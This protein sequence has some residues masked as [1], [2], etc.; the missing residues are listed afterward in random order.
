MNDREPASELPGWLERTRV[1]HQTRNR[2]RWLLYGGGGA[3]IAVVALVG[4]LYWYSLPNPARWFAGQPSSIVTAASPAGQWS[5]LGHRPPLTGY[6]ADVPQLPAGR[7]AWSQDLGMPTRSAPLA[8]DGVVYVGGHFT[9][10]ALDA[11]DGGMLWTVDTPGPMDHALTIANNGLVF[12]GQTN[13]RMLALDKETGAVAWEFQA[14]WPI[15]ASALVHDGIAYATSAANVIYAL[16]AQTGDELWTKRIKGNVKTTPAL[17]EGYLFVADDEGNLYRLDAKRGRQRFRYRTV[18]SA[19]GPPVYSDGVVY[20][21][22]GGS[23]YAVDAGV[24]GLPGLFWMKRAWLQLWIWQIPLVPPAPAQRG[25]L[26]RFFPESR[27]SQGVTASPAIAD[28]RYYIGDTDGLFYARD[29]KT[30]DEHWRI[31]LG[32]PVVSSPIALGS[33]VYVGARDGSLYAINRDN[34]DVEWTLDLGAAIDLPPAY[35]G[36]R[37]FVRTADGMMHAV[38]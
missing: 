30:D 21:P 31:K 4:W 27:A 17:A 37:L 6:V 20:F 26:W 8:A 23:L 7:L 32:G 1:D 28:G 2:A 5:M 19:D 35:A 38:E 12:V 10:M 15:T 24:K 3:L 25:D 33:R 13:H 34:G 29:A 16:D 18:G 22:S 9:V 36:G 11:A 14:D